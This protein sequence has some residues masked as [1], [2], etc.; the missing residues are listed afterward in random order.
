MEL[1]EVSI[2]AGHTMV[3][4]I[5]PDLRLT[6]TTGAIPRARIGDTVY[7]VLPDAP[8]APDAWYAPG[9]ERIGRCVC[10]SCATGSPN[11]TPRAACRGRRISHY[12]ILAAIRPAAWPR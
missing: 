6:A 8:D 10:F 11:G 3:T 12:R 2:I 7:L 1:A 5:R 9:G 4:T